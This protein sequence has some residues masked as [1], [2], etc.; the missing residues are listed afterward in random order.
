MIMFKAAIGLSI[1][2]R[3]V[4]VLELTDKTVTLA[5]GSNRRRTTKS[6]HYAETWEDAKGWLIRN[7]SGQVERAERELTYAKYELDKMRF[8]TK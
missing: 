5:A 8:L 3:E 4:D 7:A 6:E 1:P 2:I